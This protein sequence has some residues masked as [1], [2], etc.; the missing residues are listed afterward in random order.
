MLH[1]FPADQ[2]TDDQGL[3]IAQ[4]HDRP[5]LARRNAVGLISGTNTGV[6]TSATSWAVTESSGWICGV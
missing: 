1:L 3:A 5:G 4:T 2:T 6:L